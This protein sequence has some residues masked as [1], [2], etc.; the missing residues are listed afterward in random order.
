MARKKVE[1]FSIG[2][3]NNIGEVTPQILTGLFGNHPT[4]YSG[5]TARPGA[6]YEN[7]EPRETVE[8]IARKIQDQLK[9]HPEVKQDREIRFTYKHRQP[10]KKKLRYEI[11]FEPNSKP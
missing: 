1:R 9:Q 8:T 11:A 4:I 2:I 5:I 7:G 3:V 6:T 10:F